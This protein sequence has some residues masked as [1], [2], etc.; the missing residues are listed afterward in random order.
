MEKQ[1]EQQQHREKQK[2]L[3]DGKAIAKEITDELQK[4]VNYSALK[5]HQHPPPGLAVILVGDRED[6]KTYVRMK[7]RTAEQIGIDF[8]LHK[9]P[10]HV[11]QQQL[12]KL[13]AKLNMDAKIHGII[14]QLPLPDHIDAKHV[15]AQVEYHKDVDGFHPYNMGKLALQG[16]E[17][18]F[19]A[20]TARGVVELLDRCG[21]NLCGA[22]VVIVGCGN[23]VGKPLGLMLVK[24]DATVC[25]CH[26][27]TR[28]ISSIT[29]TADVLI[30]AAGVAGLIKADWV[31]P[32]TIVIDVGINSILDVTC[33]SGK[34]LVGDV[35]FDDVL[36][37]ASR[38]TPVP[39][40]VG[41]MTVAML[42]KATVESWQRDNSVKKSLQCFSIP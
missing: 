7:Q 11:T 13:I 3:I 2:K 34:R 31:S 9:L 20:C 21:V 24:R 26:S 41:P 10:I 25:W 39:G 36:P 6:S 16:H 17:P 15:T 35:C 23:V 22:K 29:K 14:I 5:N 40:G 8:Q 37:I 1:R 19:V 4:Q 42:M 27:E 12:E 30:S 32:G 38:I 33:S 18:L 28:D